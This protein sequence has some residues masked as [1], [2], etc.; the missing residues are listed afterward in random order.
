MVK[1]VIAVQFYLNRNDEIASGHDCVSMKKETI[2]IDDA[3]Q[4]AIHFIDFHFAS[5][6]DLCKKYGCFYRDTVGEKDY[7]LGA[8]SM[9]DDL[10]VF[11]YH[12]WL[13]VFCALN[14]VED[15]FI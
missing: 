10:G 14:S 6:I 7:L 9:L 5:Y 1:D 11:D 3:M 8:C 2:N 15:S 12:T 4:R 13:F